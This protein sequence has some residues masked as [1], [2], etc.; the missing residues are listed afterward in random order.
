MKHISFTLL[1][2]VKTNKTN[3]RDELMLE[4]YPNLGVRTYHLKLDND[5]L[6]P[7]IGVLVMNEPF[8]IEK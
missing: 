1:L 6:I 2:C 3:V 4:S 5:L 8:E 7:N